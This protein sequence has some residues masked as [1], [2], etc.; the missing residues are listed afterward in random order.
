MADKMMRIA[1]RG[2]DG[3]AKAIK[4]NNEGELIFRGAAA[5]RRR[6]AFSFTLE[7]NEEI[8]YE[9]KLADATTAESSTYNFTKI[10]LSWL[11]ADKFVEDEDTVTI[12]YHRVTGNTTYNSLTA[13]TVLKLGEG[14][15]KSF[16]GTYM[17]NDTHAQTIMNDY[18][19]ITFKNNS[20][21]KKGAFSP[22]LILKK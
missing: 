17:L 20:G 7:P 21:G 10:E 2:I 16:N 15:K 4:T 12:M 18:V 22:T 6:L 1:G 13:S 5:E 3:T 8:S 14:I 9:V 11:S 19:T